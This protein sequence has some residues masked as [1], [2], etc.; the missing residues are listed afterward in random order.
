MENKM[1]NE[2]LIEEFWKMIEHDKRVFDN[3]EVDVDELDPKYVRMVSYIVENLMS[4][5]SMVELMNQIMYHLMRDENV[6][7]EIKHYNFET[8][9][10]VKLANVIKTALEKQGLKPEIVI[11]QGS[12]Q[13]KTDGS[14]SDVLAGIDS[15]K[16][17]E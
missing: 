11:D 17:S 13:V 9:T 8:I 3:G 1:Q 2:K 10:S 12:V 4:Y 6:F 15:I 7:E 5:K 14:K 16:R